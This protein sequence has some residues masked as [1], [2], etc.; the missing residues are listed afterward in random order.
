MDAVQRERERERVEDNNFF[1]MHCA[2]LISA[3][4][5]IVI[6]SEIKVGG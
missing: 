6:I 3:K 1:K 2:H 5:I 4:K